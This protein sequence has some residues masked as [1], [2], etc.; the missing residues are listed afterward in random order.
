MER[1]DDIP[2]LTPAVITGTDL[3]GHNELRRQTTSNNPLIFDME[4]DRY[5]TNSKELE[6]G[7]HSKTRTIQREKLVTV[8]EW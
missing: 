5:D 6:E 4:E 2:V 8:L 7:P 3:V 1:K